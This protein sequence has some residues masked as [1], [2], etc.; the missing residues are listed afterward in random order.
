MDEKIHIKNL[1]EMSKERDLQEQLQ[2]EK[3]RQLFKN[4]GKFNATIWLIRFTLSGCYL[5]YINCILK[6]SHLLP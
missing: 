5:L 1:T 4:E 6:G 3:L 2:R